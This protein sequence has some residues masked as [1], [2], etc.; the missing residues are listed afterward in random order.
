MDVINQSSTMK[1]SVNAMLDAEKNSLSK[2]KESELQDNESTNSI[3]PQETSTTDT[4][5]TDSEETKKETKEEEEV[6]NEWLDVLGS[7][8]L[9]KKVLRKAEDSFRAV[10]SNIV[11]INIEGKLPD[12]SVVDKQSNLTLQVGDAEHIQALDIAL[13]LM[14]VGELALLEV[15]PRFAYGSK[16]RDPD[17]PPN[18]TIIG[19][20]WYTRGEHTLAIQC[21][22]RALNFLDD[23]EGGIIL[24]SNDSNKPSQILSEK[25]DNS[26]AV[27]VLRQASRLEP[28]NTLIR[29]DLLRILTLHREDTIHEKN[30]YKKMLG[31]DKEPEDN[32]SPKNNRGVTNSILSAQFQFPWSILFGTLAAVVAGVVAYRYKYI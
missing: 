16:G 9:K 25:G 22:R 3:E 2:L 12:G 19:N 29:Q 21:Y 6:E 20:Y 15:G 10:R 31:Q 23:V 26:Q 17:V 28:D 8:Q 32:N 4:K 18:V 11:V 27:T 5:E 30:L 7:G 24:P 14:E 13:T 1:D